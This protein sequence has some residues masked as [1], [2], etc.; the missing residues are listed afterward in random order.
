MR[1]AVSLSALALG[2]LLLAIARSDVSGQRAQDGLR[3]PA[4]EEA[5]GACERARRVGMV[6]VG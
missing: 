4:P 2:A 3:R 5:L 1:Q 6:F